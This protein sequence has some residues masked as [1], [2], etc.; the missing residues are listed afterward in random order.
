MPI[1]RYIDRRNVKTTMI[2]SEALGIPLM[3]I[4]M[5]Q[6]RYEV[7]VLSEILFALTAATW[8]PVLSTYLARHVGASERS[9][10]FGRLNMFR[11]LVAFPA[12]TIGGL[13]YAWGGLWLPLLANLLGIFVVI[14][15]LALFVHEPSGNPEPALVRS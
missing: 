8:I 1:G 12:P 7:F 4:W 9:E 3:L 15:I 5:T 10:A 6:N 11:G 14:G 2:V 13:L